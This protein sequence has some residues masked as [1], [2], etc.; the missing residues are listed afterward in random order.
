MRPGLRALRAALPPAP[1][2]TQLARSW[3]SSGAA[4][5]YGTF[6]ACVGGR[7]GG[8]K[9]EAAACFFCQRRNAPLHS[10]SLPLCRMPGS[11]GS[12]C[13]KQR[14]KQSLH[15]PSA[16][17]GWP[18]QPLP[19]VRPPWCLQFVFFLGGRGG[20]GEGQCVRSSPAPPAASELR[21]LPAFRPPPPPPP[22]T[23]T[24]PHTHPAPP[25]HTHT[26][27]K[28]KQKGEMRNKE[29][30]GAHLQARPPAGTPRC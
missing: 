22:H 29:M 17:P 14:L 26:H 12:V 30:E 20:K 7:G 13:A 1:T 3:I 5:T 18:A 24:H 21:R 25:P 9:R 15:D 2:C 8:G 28:M 10:P 16:P 19:A 27:R 6:L 4:T 23:H 11:D